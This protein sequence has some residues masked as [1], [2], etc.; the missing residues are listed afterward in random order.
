[1]TLAVDAG[2][3]LLVELIQFLFQKLSQY[4]C[5]LIKSKEQLET[6]T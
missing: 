2:P 5:E 6:F 1:M 3:V 4:R